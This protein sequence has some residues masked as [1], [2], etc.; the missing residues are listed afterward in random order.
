MSQSL[1][2]HSQETG[3]IL[4]MRSNPYAADQELGKMAHIFG[5]DSLMG[6]IFKYVKK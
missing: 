2:F 1:S 6:I 5:T 4:K 3:Q